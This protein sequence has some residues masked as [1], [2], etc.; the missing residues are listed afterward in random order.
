[1]CFVDFDRMKSRTMIADADHRAHPDET[2]IDVR[3]DDALGER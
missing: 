1:M 2:P 3:G